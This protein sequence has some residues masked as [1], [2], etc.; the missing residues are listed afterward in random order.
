MNV[1]RR[2]AR[3]MGY[4]GAMSGKSLTDLM[5]AMLDESATA[6]EAA[7]VERTEEKER[8]RQEA[9]LRAKAAEHA[10]D[11]APPS[12]DD[13]VQLTGLTEGDLRQVLGAAAPDDL[14]VVLA[15]ADGALQRRILRNLTEESVKW[16][17]AN[18]EHMGDVN[19]HER[20]QARA[21]VLKKANQLL[22]DGTI[23]L[24]E[25]ESIGNDEAPDPERKELRELLVDLVEIGER[26]GPSALRQ[27]AD[28]AGEPLLREGIHKVVDGSDSDTLRSEL[29][30]L[31]AELERRYAQRLKWM[32]E[33]LVAIREGETADSFSKRVF[34]A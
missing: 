12:L 29:G 28:S 24:P 8:A 10:K 32:V 25:P 9:T 15:T 20:D 22:A 6:L 21:K 18:L 5:D 19:D 11:E 30:E 34:K 7:E 31:R 23:G 26:S 17:R 2:G 14:L 33:A 4:K 13:V 16:M 27:I 1:V 3:P